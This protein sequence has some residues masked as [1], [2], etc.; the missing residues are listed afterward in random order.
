M[1]YKTPL[2]SSCAFTS[3]VAVGR[4][5][6]AIVRSARFMELAVAVA[7]PP[8]VVVG[9]SGEPLAALYGNADAALNKGGFGAGVV[10]LAD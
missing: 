3:V 2:A 6:F 10:V 5:L 9:G 7:E 4:N 8:P 1:A